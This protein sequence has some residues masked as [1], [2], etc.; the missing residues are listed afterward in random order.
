MV[1]A[2]IEYACELLDADQPRPE[3]VESGSAEPVCLL[4]DTD[5]SR[6]TRRRADALALICESFLARGPA[7][8]DERFQV[9]IH[10]TPDEVAGFPSASD[11]L[12]LG[13]RL[14]QMNARLLG[15]VVTMVP[16]LALGGMY[17]YEPAA[18]AQV[19][20]PAGPEPAV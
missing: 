7:A 18:G 10:A 2:A 17:S 8:D 12:G 14:D 16:S 11:G 19:I 13:S 3:P 20:R 15:V 9:V 1:D 6:F 4:P 5:P